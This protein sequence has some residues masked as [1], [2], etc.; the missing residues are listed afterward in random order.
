MMIVGCVV[1]EMS[2][3]QMAV[4]ACFIDGM[5]M[6]IRVKITMSMMQIVDVQYRSL[7]TQ[8]RQREQ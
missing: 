2:F 1:S 5:S 4:I 3:T 8:Q 6:V 7:R